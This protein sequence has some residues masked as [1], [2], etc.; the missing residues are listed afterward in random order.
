MDNLLT[1]VARFARTKRL[2]YLFTLAII[3]SVYHPL[4]TRAPFAKRTLYIMHALTF[5]H[6]DTGDRCVVV[7]SARTM[8]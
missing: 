8:G 6:G 2:D 3:T 5:S 1:T 7:G 4:R